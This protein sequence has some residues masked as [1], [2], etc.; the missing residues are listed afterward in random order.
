MIQREK[1][2]EILNL[3][4]E[5]RR[6]L[7]RVLQ[8]SLP[9][10]GGDTEQFANGDQVSPA[11]KWLL[12]MAGRYSGGSGIPPPVPTRSSVPRSISTVV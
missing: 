8:E 2:E 3:P 12:S 1:I 4:L 6:Q 11:A 10:K 7:L 5:E 9:E